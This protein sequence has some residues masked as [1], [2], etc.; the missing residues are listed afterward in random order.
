M[1][2]ADFVQ[3]IPKIPLTTY[4]ITC[5]KLTN[6]YAQRHIISVNQLEES[7]NLLVPDHKELFKNKI[8]TFNKDFKKMTELLNPKF[9]PTS[10]FEVKI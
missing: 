1:A 10:G 6:Y 2:I 9:N 4:L 8:I 5:S 7:I 3:K